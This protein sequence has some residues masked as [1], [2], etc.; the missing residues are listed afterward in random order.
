[1]QCGDSFLEVQL[2]Y[3]FVNA[4]AVMAGRLGSFQTLN[5]KKGRESQKQERSLQNKLT[6]TMKLS[7]TFSFFPHSLLISFL[8]RV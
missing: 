4:G 3:H 6:L 8:N 5:L 2:G 7:E 1:M